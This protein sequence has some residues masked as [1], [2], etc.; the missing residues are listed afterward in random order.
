MI[1]IY[2]QNLVR[3][4]YQ[5]VVIHSNLLLSRGWL[6]KHLWYNLSGDKAVNGF[7]YYYYYDSCYICTIFE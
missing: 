5:D 4:V 3:P 7:I 2:Y 6:I 1:N